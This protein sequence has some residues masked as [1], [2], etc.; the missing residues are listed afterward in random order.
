MEQA[1]YYGVDVSTPYS[2]T[3]INTRA[4]WTHGRLLAGPE[5]GATSAALQRADDGFHGQQRRQRLLPVNEHINA[6]NYF[7]LNGS[8]QITKNVKLSMTVNNL[9]DKQPPLVGTGI[10]PG[11][12]QLRQHLPDRLRHHRSPLHRHR[13]PPTSK[14]EVWLG[15]SSG[16]PASNGPLGARFFMGGARQSGTLSIT[17]HP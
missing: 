16:W 14:S 9:F 17:T 12:V 13:A 5:L 10:G 7:D 2:K 4:S 11:A 8:W 15:H 1:G 6:F 3:R